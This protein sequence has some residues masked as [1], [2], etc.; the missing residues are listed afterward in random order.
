[1]EPGDLSAQT[2]KANPEI[3]RGAGQVVEQEVQRRTRFHFFGEL[4]RRWPCGGSLAPSAD[5]S[6]Q[7]LDPG[8][9]SIAD[10]MCLGR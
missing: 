2:K 5:E 4:L 3:E 9:A 1:M 10:V 7:L 6:L 8:S